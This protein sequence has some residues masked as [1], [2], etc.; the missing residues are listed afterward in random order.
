MVPRTSGAR[1][2]ARRRTSEDRRRPEIQGLR[3]V[4]VGLV[5]V[6]HLWPNRLGGGYLGVDVFFVISGFLITSHLLREVAATGRVRL[7]QFWARRARRLLPAAYL[8]LGVSL[9][10]TLLWVP[11]GLWRQFTREIGAAAV[12]VE[13]WQLAHDAVDYLAESNVPSPAQH[14]WTLSAEEQFYLIWPLL[15]LLGIGIAAL[16]RRRGA[17]P[18]GGGHR[19]ERV[20]IAA[21]LG[22]A[23]AA[24]LAYSLWL[25]GADPARAYFVTTTRAWEFGAGALLA[26]VPAAAAGGSRAV[27]ALLSWA[28]LAVIVGSALVFDARTPMPG[29]AAIWVVVAT[30]VV[31]W[32][33]HPALAWSPTHLLAWRPVQAIGDWSYAI[34]LWH[35]PLVVLLPYATGH[36]LTTVDKVTIAL[37]SVAL[38]A[39]TKRLVEDPVRTGRRFGIRRPAV[40]FTLTAAT[41]GALVAACVA[42][43]S[44][45]ERREAVA[46]EQRA[47]VAAHPCLGAASRDPGLAQRCDDD[48]F[49]GVIVP[50]PALAKDDDRGPRACP[51]SVAP[52]GERLVGCT[53]GDPRAG[54]PN[55]A[56]FGDS[57]ARALAPMLEP[58]V[59]HGD[60]T[61][62]MFSLPGCPW[63]TQRAGSRIGPDGAAACDELKERFAATLSDEPGRFDAVLTT[64]RF[65]SLHGSTEH[66]TAAMLEAWRP[67]VTAGVPIVALRDNPD[68]GQAPRTNPNLCLEEVGAEGAGSCALSRTKALDDI[69]DPLA[70]AVS[71]TGGATHV[72]LSRYYCDDRTCPVVIGGVDV[73]RDNNHL[74]ATYA[75]TM[76][77]YLREALV[78]AKV[79]RR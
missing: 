47:E 30:G 44:L 75:E 61:V 29:T 4:A 34:Y 69:P 58:L 54:V 26:F 46:A 18:G 35:W 20:A 38:A 48:D 66:Q 22:V 59:D 64:A 52:P 60:V 49:A 67:A 77:P 8:V 9:V 1:T 27:R 14:Y 39:A 23:V 3:A 51:E 57:H 16:A 28:G 42:G 71:R 31:L 45:V 15:I 32:A 78:E 65:T 43:A 21:V 74:T 37:A 41:A 76:A 19:R 68:A 79:V 12:Y 53:Y 33:G 5:V 50:D 72:D 13:N 11:V 70:R 25:T 7:G 63:T 24:S 36:R 56:V 73:Y 6:F 2:V 55:L 62:E 10:G 40:T 17:R